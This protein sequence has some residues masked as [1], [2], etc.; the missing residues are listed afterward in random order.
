MHDDALFAI[1]QMIVLDSHA[2]NVHCA[3][4]N[5]SQYAQAMQPPMQCTL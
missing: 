5:I 3:Y 1:N 2:L 4:S